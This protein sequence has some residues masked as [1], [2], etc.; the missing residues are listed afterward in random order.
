M[1]TVHSMTLV[2]PIDTRRR[3]GGELITRIGIGGLITTVVLA[4]VGWLLVSDLFARLEGTLD[5][6][7]DS[8]RTVG[9]TLQV[10]D[11]ALGALTSSLDTVAE[12]TSQASDSAT[13]VSEAI[14]ET[15]TIVG[16]ELPASI[17]S[18][19]AAMPGLIEASA[20]IDTTLSG[21]AFFGVPYDPGVPLDDAFRDLDQQ[22]APLPQSLRDNAATI[23]ELVPQAEGFRDQS[24]LLADQVAEINESVEEARSVIEDYRATTGQVEIVVSVA[25]GGLQRS[26]LVARIL[27]VLMTCVG[28]LTMGA[29]IHI[30]RALRQLEE[31]ASSS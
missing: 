25:T 28:I 6:T 5:V 23:S 4:I 30:G 8:L 18:I 17:E 16:G 10:A 29:F 27:V 12:A 7:G 24:L 31:P 1:G 3:L 9:V 22:L 21:L 14:S 20:V 26:E 15:A 19:R 13:T 11:E 2:G